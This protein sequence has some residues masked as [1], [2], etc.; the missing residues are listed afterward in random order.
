MPLSKPFNVGT[1][2]G[3]A[4]ISVDNKLMVLAADRPVPGNPDNV[5]LFM[6]EYHVDHR[7]E[8]DGPLVH[9]VPLD[10]ARWHHQHPNRMGIPALHQWR[11]KHIVLCLCPR[12]VHPRRNGNPTM[13][14][15]LSKRTA[16]GTWGAPER[17]PPPIN[18]EAQDKAPFLHPDG[19]TLYFSSNRSPGGGGYDLWMSQKDSA[20]QWMDAVNLGRPLNSSGDEHGLVVSTD[21][22]FGMFASRRDGTLGLDICTYTL[23][24]E[25]KPDPVTV[26]T[27]EVGWP[28][29]EGELTVSIEYV[30]SKRVEQIQISTE[31]GTFAHVVK[32]KDGEDVVMTL[33]GNEVG[34]QSRVVH[35]DGTDSG[36]SVSLDFVPETPKGDEGATFELPDVQFDTK[37]AIL[38]SRSLV[39]LSALANHM[40]RN[41]NRV[42]DIEGHTDDVGDAQDNLQLSQARAEAVRDH[43]VSGASPLKGCKSKG[44]VRP[45]RRPPTPPLRDE[46]PIVG[47]RFDGPSEDVLKACDLGCE[48]PT[49]SR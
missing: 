24:D 37:K 46:R 30:Q 18:S 2:C 7:G 3:G 35:E 13:D 15:F 36:N 22:K 25:L 48:I 21:G 34:Y 8:D 26:V 17:L 20:G 11:R 19:R 9:L 41:Q 12:R 33:E 4:S 43:L 14:I 31:D 40:D 29:P 45:P 47:P 16:D 1:N 23:P 28:V 27:G 39:I 32:L 49:G 44:T 42:L 6:T 38:S 10:S 5:D